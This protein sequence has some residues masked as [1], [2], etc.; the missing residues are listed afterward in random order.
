ME[1]WNTSKANTSLLKIRKNNMSEWE[2]D[3][4]RCTQNQTA[5]GSRG[6]R[7]GVGEHNNKQ[8]VHA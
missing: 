6:G 2:R 3:R 1:K 5:R 8:E 4:Q 7:L